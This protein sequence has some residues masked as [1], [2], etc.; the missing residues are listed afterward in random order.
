MALYNSLQPLPNINQVG[1]KTHQSHEKEH[2]N[3]VNGVFFR[4]ISIKFCLLAWLVC[5]NRQIDGEDFINFCGLL[6]KHELYQPHYFLKAA[7]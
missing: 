1:P 2:V 6:R 3:M 4:K 7:R 5:S